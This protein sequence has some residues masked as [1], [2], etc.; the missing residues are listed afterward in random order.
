MPV[1]RDKV[2][3]LLSRN[4]TGFEAARLIIADS[5]EV[6]HGRE[7]FLSE[8]DIRQIKAGL[9]G[10]EAEIYNNW[11]EAYRAVSYTIKEAHTSAL[12]AGLALKDVLPKL[13]KF[14]LDHWLWLTKRHMPAIVTQKQY[15]DIKARQREYKLQELHSLEA[16]LTIYCYELAKDRGP[17]DIGYGDYDFDAPG[18]AQDYPDLYQAG[19]AELE[20]LIQSG[21]LRLQEEGRPDFDKPETLKSFHVTGATLYEAIPDYWRK[22]IDTFGAGHVFDPEGEADAY[23][24]LQEDSWLQDRYIDERGYYKD[25]YFNTSFVGRME[26]A[27]LQAT[28]KSLKENLLETVRLVRVKIT[29]FLA[30]ET[31]LETL[32][33]AIG[34]KL[35]ED[36]ETLNEI[37]RREVEAYNN[38]IKVDSDL[39]PEEIFPISKQ[40][41]AYNLP[42]INFEKLKPK[43]SWIKYFRERLAMSLGANW[44]ELAYDIEL[45]EDAKHYNWFKEAFSGR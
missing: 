5:V 27:T 20:G 2:S 37:L 32:S 13:Q 34:V 29:T 41:K 15:E 25:K 30:I 24:I 1:T 19:R 16:V 18:L 44:W 6:D 11:I 35:T 3:K 12:E 36:L 17:T 40:L 4:L 22:D 39:L 23:A 26:E 14:Y 9:Y 21:R 10:Q 38:L 43:A 33:E 42:T 31:V 8:K 28:G 7:G 45:E